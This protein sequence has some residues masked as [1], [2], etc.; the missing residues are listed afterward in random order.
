MVA[1][2]EEFN[3]CPEKTD[4]LA[5]KCSTAN[6]LE[7]SN[8]VGDLLSQSQ[9]LRPV[10]ELCSYKNASGHSYGPFGELV[11]ETGSYVSE[12]TYKFSTKPQD[13]ETGYFYYG[14][15]YYDSA[16][17][18]WLNRD[19]L[20]E[21]GGFNLYAIVR[22]NSINNWDLL[23]LQCCGG[24]QLRRREICC[25]GQPITTGANQGCCGG[26]PYDRGTKCCQG[27][28]AIDKV[29]R[30]Q[31][32]GLSMGE[33]VGRFTSIPLGDAAAGAVVIGGAGAVGAAGSLLTGS[34][35][36][37]GSVGLG[38]AGGLIGGIAGLDYGEARLHCSQKV[39]PSN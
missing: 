7:T 11:S 21:S 26:Q 35:I 12:N 8:R 31:A 10:K 33:C 25:G 18:R 36:G 39:C 37:A 24:R 19:P 5:K 13:T 4:S 2:L 1:L 27:G 34:A 22:N 20:G 17:G 30:H 32:M 15:R 6:F 28:S 23:G 38:I 29:P 16:N 14:F 3:P 9:D